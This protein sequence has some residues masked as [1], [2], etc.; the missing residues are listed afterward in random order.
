MFRLQIARHAAARADESQLVAQQ[1]RETDDKQSPLPL[2]EYHPP[3]TPKQ[4]ARG[5]AEVY[6]DVGIC[7]E[8]QRGN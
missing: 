2:N 6:M 3:N 8:V 4:T 5:Y 7:I 1:G